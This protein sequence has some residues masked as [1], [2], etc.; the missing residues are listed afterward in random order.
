MKMKSHK[1]LARLGTALLTIMTLSSCTTSN[2]P[3][4]RG[5]EN[6]MIARGENLPVEWGEDLNIRWTSEVEGDSWTSPITWGSRVFLASS[7]PVNVPAAPERREGGQE[8]GEDESFKAEVYRWE[9]SCMDLDSGEELWKKVAFEGSPRIKK[10]RAHN[11]AAETPV[12]DGKRLYVYF[13]MMG[14]YCYDLDGELLWEKDLGAF[15]TLYDWGTGSSPVVHNGVLYVQVDNEENSFLV[16]L[17]AADGE[18]MWKVGREE[19]TNYSTP[20]IWENSSGSELIVGGK[21]ARSYDPLTG[22]LNWELEVPGHYNIPCPV[23]DQDFLYLGNAPWRDTPGTFFCVKAGAKG[24]I[25][26]A[27]GETTSSGVSWAILDAPMG[28]PSPLLHNGLIYLVSS[29]GGTVSCLDATSGEQVYQE[30]VEG[31]G[32]CWASPWLYEDQVYFTDEKGTTRIFKAGPSFELV[33]E[34][35]LDDKFWS[36]VAITSDAYLMKGTE[37]LYCIGL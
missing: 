17:D 14:V 18:E 11:Y 10:H 33:G 34:N 19:K 30:K 25:T 15:K 21:T 36:S 28:S 37:K 5:A 29:R 22:E 16:A 20:M 26:P 12:T 27:D 35:K 13:G 31:V 32:A 6:N 1:N 3:Q 2:W 4:F 9:V 8:E 24:D 7:V 23:A